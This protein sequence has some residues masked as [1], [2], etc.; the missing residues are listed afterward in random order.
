MKVKDAIKLLKKCDPQA[1]LVVQEYDGAEDNNRPVRQ[2]VE[3][4]KAELNS[5]SP[6]VVTMKAKNFVQ[7]TAFRA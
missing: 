2:V 1:V 7:I 6:A 3:L 4:T 5:P